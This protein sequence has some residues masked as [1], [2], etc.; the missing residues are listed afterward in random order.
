MGESL[1]EN[2]R[3]KKNLFKQNHPGFEWEQIYCAD[4]HLAHKATF[5][6]SFINPMISA[7]KVC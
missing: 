2:C 5:F 4:S 3:E 1:N 7:Y 6:S